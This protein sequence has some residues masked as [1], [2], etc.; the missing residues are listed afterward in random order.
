M[1][2]RLY[3]YLTAT[4]L[5]STPS[6]LA[7]GLSP[8]AYLTFGLLQYRFVCTNFAFYY[9]VAIYSIKHP[10]CALWERLS[11]SVSEM[12][13]A[14]RIVRDSVVSLLMFIMWRMQGMRQAKERMLGAVCLVSCRLPA[15]SA[16]L[17][18][19]KRWWHEPLWWTRC[20][21]DKQ[22]QVKY[23]LFLSPLMDFEKKTHYSTH[24][25]LYCCFF[26]T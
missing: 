21:T 23:W 8:I 16:E 2:I 3:Y 1:F 26:V 6:I 4:P 25:F 22:G 14:R 13:V 12:L 9:V 24:T 20:V 19:T 15:D 10:K 18:R 17:L 11:Q 7:N 5:G